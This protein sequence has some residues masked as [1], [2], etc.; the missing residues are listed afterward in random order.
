MKSFQA[1]VVTRRGDPSRSSS[2]E[3]HSPFDFVNDSAMNGRPSGTNSEA[4]CNL[5]KVEVAGSNPVSRSIYSL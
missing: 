5:A 3:D 1:K 4:E 2:L